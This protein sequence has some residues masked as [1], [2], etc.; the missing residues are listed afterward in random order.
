MCLTREHPRLYILICVLLDLQ[1]TATK[2]V[3]GGVDH[4]T[5][6]A[7]LPHRLSTPGHTRIPVKFAVNH[8]PYDSSIERFRC[9]LLGKHDPCEGAP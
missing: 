7:K 6:A 5:E 4:V 8:S 2:L 1:V 3:Q 9:E